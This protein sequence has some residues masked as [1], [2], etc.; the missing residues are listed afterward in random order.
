MGDGEKEA[1][2]AVAP[3]PA[4]ALGQRLVALADWS[5]RYAGPNGDSPA[6]VAELQRVAQQF[7]PEGF[8][9]LI[10]VEGMFGPFQLPPVF[11]NKTC[12]VYKMPKSETTAP[13][14]DASR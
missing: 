1:D 5:R 14:S 7:Q 2:A 9:Y 6:A 3:L 10:A 12:R 13:G 11:E 4:L 8:D